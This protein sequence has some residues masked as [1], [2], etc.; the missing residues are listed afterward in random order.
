MK[1]IVVI[2][3]IARLNVPTSTPNLLNV[4]PDLAAPT[5]GGARQ[6]VVSARIECRC[7]D[8]V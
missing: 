4:P 7:R 5:V 6:R 3:A 8:V 2:T 1:L